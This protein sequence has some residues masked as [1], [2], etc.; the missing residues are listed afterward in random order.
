MCTCRLQYGNGAQ[1]PPQGFTNALGRLPLGPRALAGPD[2]RPAQGRAQGR[3]QG[4]GPRGGPRAQGPMRARSA[5]LT[6]VSIYI[7]VYIGQGYSRYFGHL[8]GTRAGI[9]LSLAGVL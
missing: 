1:G 6:L 3:A 2:P 8:G 4:P 5:R 9:I 7:Y